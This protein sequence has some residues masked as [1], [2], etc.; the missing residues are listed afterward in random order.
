MSRVWFTADLHLG[1]ALVA[2]HRGF[3]DTGSHDEAICLTWRLQV[4]PQDQVWVLGDVALA[5]LDEALSLIA[6][7]PGTKHLVPGNHDACHPM[8]RNA[9][10]RQARFLRV[11]HSV[12]PF[13]RIRLNGRYVLLSHFPYRADRTAQ[14]RYS[15]YRLP[16]EGLPLLHGHTHSAERLRG[17]EL[18]VGLDAWNL[19]LVPQDT[20]LEMLSLK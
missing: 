1:H 8:H 14:V 9:H 10:K 5:G 2:G 20:V 11:F 19:G 18:H 17:R 7:L 13:A 16:D 15:Q 4:G 3:P 12:Q 6:E